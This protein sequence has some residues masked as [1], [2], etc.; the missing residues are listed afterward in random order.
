MAIAACNGIAS[1]AVAARFLFYIGPI[2][3]VMV[4]T[5]III[6]MAPGAEVSP[7]RGGKA[8]DTACKICVIYLGPYQK[9]VIS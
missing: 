6:I 1:V 7:T 8:G 4:D 5:L 3:I 2:I 9:H